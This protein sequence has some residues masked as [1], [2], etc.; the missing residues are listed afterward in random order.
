MTDDLNTPISFTKR[1]ELLL[2]GHGRK[3]DDHS[4][5]LHRLGMLMEENRRDTKLILD[6]VL[7][8]QKRMDRFDNLDQRVTSHDHRLAAVEDFIRSELKQI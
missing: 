7:N 5:E 8:T 3:L 4:V 6:V 1:H 2:I